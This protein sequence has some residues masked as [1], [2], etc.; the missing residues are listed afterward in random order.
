M[1]V[2]RS[3]LSR[4]ELSGEGERERNRI[5]KGDLRQ[6]RLSD[7]MANIATAT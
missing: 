3:M 2:Y 5:G 1:I 4:T 7:G 6:C